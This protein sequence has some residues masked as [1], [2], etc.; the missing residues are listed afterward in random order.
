MI[1]TSQSGEDAS[2]VRALGAALTVDYSR[3]RVRL[4][5]WEMYTARGPVEREF[6]APFVH[7]C[8]GVAYSLVV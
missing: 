3:R 6:F 5:H 8:E 1:A 7:V 4:L 2:F